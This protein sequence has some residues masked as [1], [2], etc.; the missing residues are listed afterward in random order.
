MRDKR[1]PKNVCGEASQSTVNLTLSPDT[2]NSE[3]KFAT[4]LEIV[5]LQFSYMSVSKPLRSIFFRS[6]ETSSLEKMIYRGQV[7]TLEAAGGS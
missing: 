5:E 1:T 3:T 7:D 6:C 2:Y 4:P